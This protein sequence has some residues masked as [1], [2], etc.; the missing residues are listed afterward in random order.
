MKFEHNFSVRS[1]EDRKKFFEQNKW[2]LEQ[3]F[4]NSVATPTPKVEETPA[5]A[6]EIV[7]ADEAETL[8][9]G[10]TTD[11]DE[12]VAAADEFIAAEG[13]VE[14]VAEE[15]PA[16]DDLEDA[17]LD[18]VEIPEDFNEPDVDF[19]HL[20]GEEDAID[21]NDLAELDTELGDDMVD[22]DSLD[23]DL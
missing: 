10:I 11:L 20:E 21:I 17:S 8:D 16:V 4:A 5:P 23:I 12:I 18:D 2:K 13:L 15:L 7:P 19:E 3:A 1:A 14:D 9:S 22:L 6:A